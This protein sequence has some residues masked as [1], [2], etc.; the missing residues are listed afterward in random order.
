MPLRIPPRS[1]SILS[2]L[3]GMK[4]DFEAAQESGAVEFSPPGQPGPLVGV[5][6]E[7]A[8]DNRAA[9]IL[10]GLLAPRPHEKGDVLG[11]LVLPMGGL[12]IGKLGQKSLRLFSAPKVAEDVL[13]SPQLLQR[14][15]TEELLRLA[16]WLGRQKKVQSGS[17]PS[18]GG[19]AED[20]FNSIKRKVMDELDLRLIDIMPDL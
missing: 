4:Q 5:R 1:Q 12:S 2:L 7:L 10:L 13:K 8:T 3:T 19:F 18:I 16:R 9:Q 20:T 17:K 11:G 14:M 15:E 6:P